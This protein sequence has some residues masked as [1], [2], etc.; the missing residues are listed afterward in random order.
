MFNQASEYGRVEALEALP[1]ADELKLSRLFVALDVV[2]GDLDLVA[3]FGVAEA[4]ALVF[5]VR[6]DALKVVIQL[7]LNLHNKLIGAVENFIDTRLRL[8]NLCIAHT[9]NSLPFNQ[10]IELL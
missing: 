5:E 2:F 8:G 4:N 1:S 6:L 9:C 3:I 10:L 7:T